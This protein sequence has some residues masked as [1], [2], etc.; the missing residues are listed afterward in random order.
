M[1]MNNLNSPW[2]SA[3]S[4]VK[5][6][7]S[8][9]SAVVLLFLATVVAGCQAPPAPLPDT[10]AFVLSDTMMRRIHLDTVRP[11]QVKQV[12]NLNGRIA[13]DPSHM[14]SV[15]AIMSGQVEQVDVELGDR[16]TRGQVL[17]K[18]RSGEVA[19]LE[20]KLVDAQSDRELAEKDLAT[21]QELYDSDLLSERKL[22]RA[23]HKLEKAKA[24]LQRMNEVFSIYTFEAGSRYVLRAPISGYVV[25]KD[26][27]PGITLPEEDHDPVFT[28]AELDRVWVLAEV[29]ESDIARVK[30]GMGA[31]VS[32]LSYPDMVLYGKV[33]GIFNILDPETRTMRIR[34]TLDNPEVLLK[35]EMIAHV[36]LTVEQDEVLP[37]IP[38]EALIF[39][40]DKQH[41]LVFK[42]K[43][44]IAVR[45]VSVAHT[46]PHTAW[47]AH[48][49]EPGEAVIDRG[50]L[51]IYRALT[52]R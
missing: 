42:D 5:R 16:V 7:C 4:S 15:Y 22:V 43:R 25:G 13:A 17:A 34:I 6:C 33:D 45:E 40:H 30:E 28:I 38:V 2:A 23:R 1:P 21:K 46:D 49:V 18:I 32:T 8:A 47:I 3:C 31:E 9:W 19:A 26:I 27:A 24:K 20:R 10:K 48:G 52:D 37:A 11:R 36:K 29:Y 41:V 12:I 35:P 14:A 50:Q 39:D 51:F 44:N